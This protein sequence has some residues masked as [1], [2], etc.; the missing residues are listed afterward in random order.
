MC[1]KKADAFPGRT[2]RFVYQAIEK[3]SSVHVLSHDDEEQ[4]FG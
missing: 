4:G 1:V 2:L 3:G